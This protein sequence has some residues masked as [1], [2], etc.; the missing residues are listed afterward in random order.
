MLVYHK[1][2][3]GALFKLF[4]SLLNFKIFCF[5]YY[6]LRLFD[7][8]VYIITYRIHKFSKHEVV[9]TYGICGIYFKANK[10]IIRS[11]LVVHKFSTDRLVD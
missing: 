9:F 10:Q 4:L 1:I 5:Y 11:K 3:K 6:V 8:E 7:R 2:Y